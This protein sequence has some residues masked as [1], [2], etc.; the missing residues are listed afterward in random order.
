MKKILVVVIAL[1]AM[2]LTVVVA[3]DAA[4]LERLQ[5]EL[6]QLVTDAEAGKISS[7]VFAK[8]MQEIQQEMTQ[9]MGPYGTMMKNPQG[10]LGQTPQ[11]QQPQ[12]VIQKTTYPGTTAGWPAA[13]AF[14][15][16][17]KTPTQPNLQTPYGITASY[18]T[19]GEKLTIYLSK[20]FNH[21]DLSSPEK[22]ATISSGEFSDTERLALLNHI[23]RA[24]GATV[25]KSL[26][27]HANS[28]IFE[29]QDPNNKSTPTMYYGIQIACRWY[30]SPIDVPV[31][32]SGYRVNTTVRFFEIE[33]EPIK[34]ARREGD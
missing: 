10:A 32:I 7:E 18:K 6:E 24:F 11:T 16:Y 31:T 5:K 17:G 4:K 1:L 12:E 15:R 14:R 29:I 8:R 30:S 33:L 34:S 22:L 21:S 26:R 27:D 19:E 23:E 13:S 25:S 20:N 28:S 2:G 9:A 3:Q